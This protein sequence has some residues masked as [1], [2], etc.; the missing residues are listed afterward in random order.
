M[1]PWSVYQKGVSEGGFP[2]SRH[3]IKARTSEEPKKTPTFPEALPV[4]W[5]YGR[6]TKWIE[7]VPEL[8]DLNRHRQK[9]S[10][11]SA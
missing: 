8:L 9:P 11:L 1:G 2:K 6:T 10:E 7:H 3:Q 4:V 5:S